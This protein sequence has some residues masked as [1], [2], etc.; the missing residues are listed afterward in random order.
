[1][2]RMLAMVCSF[3][4]NML[5]KNRTFNPRNINDKDGKSKAHEVRRAVD[6]SYYSTITLP[7]ISKCDNRVDAYDSNPCEALKR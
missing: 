3:T 1:M 7:R 6:Q 2:Q 5:L 4:I